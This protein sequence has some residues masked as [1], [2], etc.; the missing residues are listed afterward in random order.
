MEKNPECVR[1]LLTWIQDAI[2]LKSY[3]TLSLLKVEQ[4]MLGHLMNS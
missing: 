1:E 4:V 3:L 2:K